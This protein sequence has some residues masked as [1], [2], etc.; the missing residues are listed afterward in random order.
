MAFSS[1]ETVEALVEAVRAKPG[2]FAGVASLAAASGLGA[3]NLHD[4]CR[5][6]FH[7]TP[8][9]LLAKAR[10][11]TARRALIESDQAIS[12]LASDAGYEGL[13][14]FH[15]N[16]RRANGMSP[17]SFRTLRGAREFHFALPKALPLARSLAF[18]GRDPTSLTE[19]VDGDRFEAGLLLAGKPARLDVELRPGRA[20]CVI[21]GRGRLR[22]RAAAEA[23]SYLLRRI[24]L[25]ADPAPFERRVR[26]EPGL[27]TLTRGRR[28]LRIPRTGDPF[29]CLAWTVVGQQI[30]LPFARTLFR[31]LVEKT[32]KPVGAGLFTPPEPEAVAALSQAELTAVQFSQRKAEYIIDAAGLIADGQLPLAALGAG[33]ATR[34]EESLLAVRGIGPWSAHYLMMR[35]YGFEDCVPVGDAGLVRALAHFFDLPQ[36]PGP[37]ETLEL[38]ERFRPYRT[39]ATFHLWMSLEDL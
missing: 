13:S 3:S 36:R 27:L 14:S 24:G 25:E 8:A 12:E 21:H 11:A 30:S 16:F 1:L 10:M 38:M 23:H 35:G 26:T 4:L 9:R 18:L 22:A 19:R 32:G 37:A 17:A 20:R 33:S 28:G 39:F 6:H 31:R 29:E 7:A 34:A 5:Q 2:E 15:A